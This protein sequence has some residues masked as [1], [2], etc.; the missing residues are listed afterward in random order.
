MPKTLLPKP[1]PKFQPKPG[2]RP[3]RA[4]TLLLLAMAAAAAADP[5]DHDRARAALERGEVLPLAEILATVT[6]QV[7]GEVVEVELE[8][9]H[10]AWVYELKV[11]SPD[12]RML[13][14]LVDATAGRLLKQEENH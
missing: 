2:P 1:Q 7:P 12:G 10:G 9:E 13:E 5:H 4:I 8:R 6:A 11:I 3:A 14:V